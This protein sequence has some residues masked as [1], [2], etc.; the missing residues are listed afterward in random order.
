MD[1]LALVDEIEHGRDGRALAAAGH[2][3]QDDHPLVIMTELFDGRRKSQL[4]ESRNFVVDPA[5]HHAQVAALFEDIHAITALILADDVGEVRAPGFLQYLAVMLGNN[6]VHEAFHVLLADGRRAHL[7][8]DASQPHHRRQ[9]DFEMQVG[10]FVLHDHAEKLVDLRFL[11][12]LGGNF[13]IQ[14]RF[15]I[16]RSHGAPSAGEW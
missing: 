12:R 7:A 11:P 2:T 6:R 10:A 4:L 8:N 13:V 14:D 5:G 3:G 16:C 15:N 1:S 9:P